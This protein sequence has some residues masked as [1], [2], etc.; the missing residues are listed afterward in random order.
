MGRVWLEKDQLEIHLLKD[1][2]VNAQIKEGSFSLSHLG[3][4]GDLILTGST[5][6]LRKFMQEHAEDKFKLVRAK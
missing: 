2:W 4:N 5:D 3:E 1:D 6:E